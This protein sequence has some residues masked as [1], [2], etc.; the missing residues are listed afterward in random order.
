MS[1]E[2]AAAR[3]RDGLARRRARIAFPW[4]MYAAAWFL[5]ALPPV[6]SDRLLSNLPGKGA[7][8]DET[9]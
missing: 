6:L 3:I 4:P 5:A 1:A 7:L 9:R 8:E 2:A